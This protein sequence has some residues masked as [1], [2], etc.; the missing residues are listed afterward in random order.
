MIPGDVAISRKSC[1]QV[2]AEPSQIAGGSYDARAFLGKER[3]SS[4]VDTSLRLFAFI[5]LV[6]CGGGQITVQSSTQVQQHVEVMWGA[7]GQ[8][9][10]SIDFEDPRLVAALADTERVMGRQ[11]DFVF[12]VTRMP[13]P[14]GPFFESMF[15]RQVGRIPLEL[16]RL[17]QRDPALFTFLQRNMKQVSFDYNGARERGEIEYDDESGVLRY[18][19]TAPRLGRGAI[20]YAADEAYRA[21]LDARFLHRPLAEIEASELSM[22]ASWIA[23]RRRRGEDPLLRL[24]ELLAVWEQV[25]V[26]PSGQ[27]ETMGILREEISSRASRLRDQ[28]NRP[29]EVSPLLDGTARDFAT[30]VTEEFDALEARRQAGILRA[31]FVRQTNVSGEEDRF[32]RDIYP[33]LD[34]YAFGIRLA[35]QWLTAGGQDVVGEGD[36]QSEMTDLICP[37]GHGETPLDN[38]RCRANGGLWHFVS[39]SEELRG[40]LADTIREVDDARFTLTA[41]LG[42]RDTNATAMI[43]VW[44]RLEDSPAHWGIGARVLGDRL[45]YDRNHGLIRSLYDEAVGAWRRKPALRGGYLYIMAANEYPGSSHNGVVPFDNF[46]RVFG[47]AIDARTLRDFF[48]V[49]EGAMLRLPVIWPA[50]ARGA[51][52]SVIEPALTRLLD[53]GPGMA[54]RSGFRPL[55]TVRDWLQAMRSAGDRAAQSAARRYFTTRLRAHPSEERVL[56]GFIALTQ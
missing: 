7:G 48:Q 6:G 25:K 30:F 28:Y 44:H 45:H 11:V 24:S 52:A 20:E 34:R 1:C 35:R 19:L 10:E 23:S 40:R 4:P 46:A 43:D 51:G 22:Y 15:D 18:L 5:A 41:L 31:L 54:H 53:D 55:D 8:G 50:I 32:V 2:P 17:S 37:R 36:V 33:G 12:D 21:M 16:E 14:R 29:R 38:P 27:E 9:G 47:G 39:Y 42:L 3:Y 13:R 26:H 49:S 56:Q